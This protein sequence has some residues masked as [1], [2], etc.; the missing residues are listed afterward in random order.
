MRI[1]PPHEVTNHGRYLESIDLLY[2]ENILNFRQ[3]RTVEEFKNAILPKRLLA[4]RSIHLEFPLDV[5]WSIESDGERTIDGC[6]ALWPFDIPSWWDPAWDAIA[7]MK[8]LQNL[9]VSL[10]QL[11]K[12]KNV[13]TGEILIHLFQSMV[14]IKV[15]NFQVKLYWSVDV[16]ELQNHFNGELPFSIEVIPRPIDLLS[17]AIRDVLVY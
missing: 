1:L 17:S 5:T 9:R 16:E 10:S 11:D 2:S 4:V 14:P 6:L 8:G 12:P 15:P 13:P 3:T 7:E